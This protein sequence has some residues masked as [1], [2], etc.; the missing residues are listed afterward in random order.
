[1]HEHPTTGAAGVELTKAAEQLSSDLQHAELDSQRIRSLLEQENQLRARMET[2]LAEANLEIHRLI[3]DL[4]EV[5]AD[6]EEERT[7]EHRFRK[8]VDQLSG[9][10]KRMHRTLF[11][12][13]DLPTLLLN[14]SIS[15]TG[16][17]RGL[18]VTL[19]KDGKPSRVKAADNVAG[20]PGSPP[21][22]YVI[23]IV[24]RLARENDS[25]VCNA[26][27]DPVDGVA[28][29]RPEE[30]WRNFVATPV[31]IHGELQAVII[32]ADKREG[33][34]SEEEVETLL[35]IGDH[36]S[37]ALENRHLERELQAAY[38]STV[39]VLADAVQAK[40]SYTHG[41]CELVSRLARLT[42]AE[43]DL[44]ET[45]R[46]VVCFAALLHDVG[47]I[48]VSDGVLNKPGPLLPEERDLVRTHVRIGHDLLAR[49][50]SLTR[51]AEVVLHHHE[52][53]DGRGYPDGLSA[54][55]IHVAARIVAVAD[56]YGAMITRRSYSDALPEDAAVAELRRCAGTQFDPMVVDA[57]A[58]VVAS[59]PA[60]ELGDGVSQC[61]ILPGLRRNDQE[62]RG[63]ASI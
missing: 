5:R 10:V 34:F 40:D 14:A 19:P 58:R 1:M 7:K 35:S 60:T 24:E 61:G 50:P 36:G 56:A 16:A 42:A 3:S 33:A 26:P 20:Y 29:S 57:F 13:H 22:A 43:L 6:L 15:L 54:H 62:E 39:G 4:E 49:V 21:S 59:S 37:V 27:S 28:P 46:D 48:G 47:K 23:A 17:R 55:E 32:A 18:Y 41:H 44:S 38:L 25:F 51:V 8:R 30:K 45:D 31:N 63:I 2:Q 53:Y 12:A 9:V 52:W 11:S